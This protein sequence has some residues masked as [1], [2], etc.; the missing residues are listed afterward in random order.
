MM[1]S[2]ASDAHARP[3]EMPA[4]A[5]R[6]G[7]FFIDSTEVTNAQFAAFVE[8]T[9]Y[10]SVAERPVDWE[11]L[12]KQV[13]ASTP[14][15]SDEM[16]QPGSLVF[17]PPEAVSG[18]VDYSQ[19]W[20]WTAG[21][22]WR[23]PEGPDSTID[24]RSDHPVVHV[25]FEDAQAF[26]KWAGKRLPTEAEWE[27]AARGGIARAAYPWG[28]EMK[29]GGESRMNIWQGEF[30]VGNSRDDGFDRTNPVRAFSPNPWGLYGVAGNVWE[31][32]S[33]AYNP[34]EYARL[35]ATHNPGEVIVDP[36]GPSE[37]GAVRRV[38]RG[39]SF[40]CHESYCSSYRVAARMST[41]ADSSMSHLG[42][43]CAQDL[44]DR[45]TQQEH[46]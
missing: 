41:T 14:K 12:R 39:G 35:I 29:P 9:G 15:P 42:F 32:C 16:L 37:A 43:R 40:L 27:Y 5:V 21:A 33:D 22:S 36:K 19:W 25:C 13:P 2:G 23:H 6:V 24:S 11:E 31:W 45:A 8:A 3:D 18:L 17:S 34:S 10:K 4:H 26:A 1:G 44:V 28:D 7:S 38:H 46:P 30:P 20:K